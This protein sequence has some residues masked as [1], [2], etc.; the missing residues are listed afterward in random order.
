LLKN[1]TLLLVHRIL[2]GRQFYLVFL[3]SCDFYG[4]LE[5]GRDKGWKLEVLRYK[6]RLFWVVR[7]YIWDIFTLKFTFISVQLLFN[8][9]LLVLSIAHAKNPV[10]ALF[11][12][13]NPIILT[14]SWRPF[15]CSFFRFNWVGYPSYRESWL[16]ICRF[17][18]ILSKQLEIVL[19]INWSTLLVSVGFS[20]DHP[21][22]IHF[23]ALFNN[24]VKVVGWKHISLSFSFI[25]CRMVK[26]GL[27]VSIYKA[28]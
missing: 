8:Y 27:F 6:K 10:K 17:N 13:L 12:H 15:L 9:L 4:R 11:F 20:N 23:Y 3:T 22:I 2:T 7:R 21:F 24:W 25:L 28:A 19:E 5:L 14:T 1:F 18:P 16:E 26:L